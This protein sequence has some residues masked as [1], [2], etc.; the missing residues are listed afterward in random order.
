MS[1]QAK[2]AEAERKKRQ[3]NAAVHA[4]DFEAAVRWYNQAIELDPNNHLLFSNRSA[5]FAGCG[6]WKAAANDAKKCLRLD[7]S[8]VKGYVRLAT[9]YLELGQA[10][11]SEFTAEKGLK[12]DPEN[13]QLSRLVEVCQE[14]IPGQFFCSLYR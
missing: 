8:F 11:K 10:E 12:L 2:R 14:H 1:N 6:K 13:T 4:K 5:A 9:A 7:E 3:G